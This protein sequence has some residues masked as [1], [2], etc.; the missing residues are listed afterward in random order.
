MGSN[1]EPGRRVTVFG[2]SGFIGRH[3][4]RRLAQQGW[5]VRAC[6]RD[7]VAAAFLKPMGNVAQVVPMRTN[8][9]DD[10]AAL[11]SAVQGAD[12]VVNLVG[13]L[14]E[15]GTQTFDA[16]QA[17][18]PGRLARAAKEAGATSFVQVSALGADA[19]SN[20]KYARTKAAGEAGVRAAFPQATIV[21]PSIVIGAEDSFFNRFA[22]MAQWMPALPLIGGGQTKFQPVHVADVAEAI[23]RAIGNPTAQGKIFEAV[24][25]RVYTFRE[26]MEYL[27]VT[28][29][30][31][32]GLIPVPWPLA[33]IQGT[34]LGMLPI[35]LM[36]RDQVEL[37]KT[38]NVGTG[39]P[40][41]EAFGIVPA[42]M[43]AVAPI[44][45][46]AYRRGGRFAKKANA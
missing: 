31:H 6:V 39:A 13:I 35:K 44:Y 26:L 30:R 34:I 27:L 12:A 23:V 40:G 28:I 43:E 38:D 15:S 2:G 18:G 17:E 16:L 1:M 46:A 9:A 32:R 45:L 19:N 37:L 21:R 29:D 25:P 20:S 4:V 8:L 33:E 10:D 11:A 22:Q 14:A 42:A 41:L 3:V 7:P 36:T 24:G 5:V